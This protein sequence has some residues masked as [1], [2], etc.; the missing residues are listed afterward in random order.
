[1]EVNVYTRAVEMVD[2]WYELAC[3]EVD[4]RHKKSEKKKKKVKNSK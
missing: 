2:A 3:I 4:Q 1:M